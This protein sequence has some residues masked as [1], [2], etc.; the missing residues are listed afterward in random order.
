[1]DED[2]MKGLIMLVWFAVF[3]CLLLGCAAHV[4]KFAPASVQL[5]VEY[6]RDQSLD[7]D[8]RRSRKLGTSACVTFED[9][10]AA[11]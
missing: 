5:C 7:E 6:S 8:W 10:S 3:G 4:P 1:V 11:E 9:Y 2:I